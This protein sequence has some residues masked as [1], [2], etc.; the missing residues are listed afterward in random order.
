MLS[1]KDYI[2]H[3]LTYPP[4]GG[5]WYKALVM[6][7]LKAV[8]H[9]EDVEITQIKEKFG[10]LRLY[11]SGPEWV[12]QLAEALEYASELFCEDCGRHNNTYYGMDPL[13]VVETKAVRGWVRTLCG[14]C[15]KAAEIVN[16]IEGD[17][18]DRNDSQEA[19]KE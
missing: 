17:S 12:M 16:R 7:F 2:Q 8:E 10:S 6:P 18:Y 4:V 15:R 1:S 14:P 11:V 13:T 9:V 5:G 19:V 3:L